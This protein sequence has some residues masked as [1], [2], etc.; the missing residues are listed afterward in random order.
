MRDVVLFSLD[1]DHP[2]YSEFTFSRVVG[3]GFAIGLNDH[4]VY[5]RW[6]LGPISFTVGYRTK[7]PA[8]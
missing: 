4:A 8:H 5:L 3:I 2:Y 7:P 6:R 1:A